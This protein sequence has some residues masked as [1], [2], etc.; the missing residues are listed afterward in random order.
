[1]KRNEGSCRACVSISLQTHRPGGESGRGASAAGRGPYTCR[2]KGKGCSEPPGQPDMF[3]RPEGGLRTPAVFKCA[4]SREVRGAQRATQ[5]GSG[6][7]AGTER[8]PCGSQLQCCEQGPRPAE[9]PLQDF[10]GRHTPRPGPQGSGVSRAHILQDLER[11]HAFILGC[12]CSLQALWVACS[13]SPSLLRLPS[14]GF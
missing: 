11:L 14:C 7:L 9:G 8:L 2:G 13:P 6:S 3:F 1:M 10:S 5:C 4:V 12:L